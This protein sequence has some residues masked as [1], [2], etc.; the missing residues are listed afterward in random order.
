MNIENHIRTDL[1]QV[2]TVPYHQIH[3]HSTGNPNA[4]VQ[5]EIDY[6]AGK[7]IEEGFYTHIVGNGRVIQVGAVNRG[8]WD[9]GNA[10]NYETYAA[11]EFI[12]SHATEAEFRRDYALYIQLL[13]DLA[14][15]AGLPVVVD[16]G[17]TGILTHNYSTARNNV[18][19]GHTDPYPY[20]AKWGITPAQFKKDV[21][22]GAVGSTVTPI[23]TESPATQ[24]TNTKG[25]A[26]MYAL[27][28]YGGKWYFY[29]G[30]TYEY[31]GHPDSLVII[32]E[33]YRKNNGKEIP[34]FHWKKGAPWWDRLEQPVVDLQ[35][36]S[37]TVAKIAKKV[38][39]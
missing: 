24:T 11:V 29:N 20:F 17:D 36:L 21:E 30:V 28:E 1:P 7:N 9:V 23:K 35:K 31:V 3:A 38:G 8:A 5:N 39:V 25:V 2:G 32:K 14:N 4:T 16:S 33:V 34:E 15:Q 19:G 26:T 13:R 6:F 27:Y 12:E 37:D 18:Y 10:D 22:S